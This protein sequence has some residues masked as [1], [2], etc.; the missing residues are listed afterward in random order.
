MAIITKEQSNEIS[1]MPIV[2]GNFDKPEVQ[3]AESC[4]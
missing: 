2:A 1:M 3:V 4:R